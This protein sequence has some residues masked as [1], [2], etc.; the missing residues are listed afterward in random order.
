MDDGKVRRLEVAPSRSEVVSGEVI[1]AL[2]SALSA[3]EAGVSR[4]VCLML[5][6]ADGTLRFRHTGLKRLELIGALEALKQE[7]WGSD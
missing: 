6:D 2:R 1:D 3:A 5:V 4:G 7:V